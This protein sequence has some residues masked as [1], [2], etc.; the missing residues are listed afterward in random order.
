M[1]LTITVAEL[2]AA[3]RVTADASTP[4]TE[5]Q[6]SILHRQLR[7]AEAFIEDYANAAPDDVQNEAAIRMV[8]YLYDG[9]SGE[10]QPEREHA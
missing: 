6:L 5:P 3:V 8:G 10:P 1:P 7:V 9:A 2:A 4:R